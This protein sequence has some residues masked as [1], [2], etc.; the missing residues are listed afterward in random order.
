MWLARSHI[1]ASLMF[2]TRNKVNAVKI[3][4]NL[5][6]ILLEYLKD[7]Y[8]VT[9]HRLLKPHISFGLNFRMP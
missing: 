2:A 7:Y 3:K 6:T 5:R 1:L 8:F 9:T 4:D